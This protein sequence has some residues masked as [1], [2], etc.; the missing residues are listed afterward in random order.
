LR[1]NPEVLK[2]AKRKPTVVL[3][4]SVACSAAPPPALDGVL[5]MAVV[6][7]AVVV[8]RRVY[9]L[10]AC[11]DQRRGV[12][13]ES[14]GDEM[15]AHPPG[16]ATNDARAL[17]VAT[18]RPDASSNRSNCAFQAQFRDRNRCDIGTSQPK[19]AATNGRCAQ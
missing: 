16:D 17:P 15:E 18:R 1:K 13:T 14:G 4:A 9:V 5:L 12:L 6:L 10:A 7:M 11:T 8:V 2:C 3:T 19:S